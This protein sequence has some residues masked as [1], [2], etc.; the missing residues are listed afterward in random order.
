MSKT[1]LL[2]MSGIVY[3]ISLF[4]LLFFTVVYTHK[5]TCDVT[6]YPELERPFEPRG[7]SPH[8][9]SECN[10]LKCV[11]HSS[12]RGHSLYRLNFAGDFLSDYKLNQFFFS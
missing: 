11:S 9:R 12:S 4:P 8:P 10:I 6:V 7:K 5:H 2:Y 3:Y 1:S